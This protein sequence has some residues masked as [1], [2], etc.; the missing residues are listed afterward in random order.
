MGQAG[1]LAAVGS[2]QHGLELVAGGGK[3]RQG[4]RCHSIWSSYQRCFIADHD[5]TTA[6]CPSGG[7]APQL[8]SSAANNWA[9]MSGRLS[10]PRQGEESLE[11]GDP[12]SAAQP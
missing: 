11:F 4:I 9:L 1:G 12:H 10:A 8:P 2:G 5:G 6:A 3:G 7:P